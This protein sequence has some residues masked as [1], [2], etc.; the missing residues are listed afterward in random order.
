LV[1]AT[2]SR[3]CERLAIVPV[4]GMRRWGRAFLSLLGGGTATEG[5][6]AVPELRRLVQQWATD[7]SFDAA[8]GT[9]SSMAPYLRRLDL[10]NRPVVVDL[11]DVDSQKWLD[12]AA[13]SCGPRACLYQL[14]GRRLR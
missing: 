6:F 9:S 12:Y 4:G 14:E 2:L 7:V 5:A 8:L 1:T 3:Y 10:R 11:V 13:A